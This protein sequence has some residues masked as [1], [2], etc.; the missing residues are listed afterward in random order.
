MLHIK[1]KDI[2]DKFFNNA[3][4]VLLCFG[5]VVIIIIEPK[6]LQF[7]VLKD[8]LTQSSVKLIVALGLMFPLLTAGTDL[9][10]GRQLGLS[11]VV[12]ASMMQVATY[13]NP[14]FPNLPAL[15]V[16]L[17]IL[18]ALAA[19]AVCGLIN[20]YMVAWLHLPPFI[21]TLGMSTIVYGANCIYYN[22][23]PNNAQPIG[24]I[25]PELT[26]LSRYQVF[27][28]M[29]LLIFIAAFVACFVWFLLNKTTY[30]K[31]IYAAGGNP[32]AAQISGVKVKPILLSAYIIES[33]LIGLAGVLEVARNSGANSSF[34]F[35]Y[36]F[37]AISAC[38][39]GG[40]SLSGG[41]GK[42]SGVIVGVIIFNVINYG[43]TF[44]GV[45][46]NWQQV[47]KGLIICM[48]VAL[49]MRKNAVRT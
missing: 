7:R 25:R 3:L 41:V 46:P 29:S 18:M 30:G 10:G 45:D 22:M 28:Q 39:V 26:I 13:P 19:V 37:D 36:E 43:L 34:G 24:G 14:F 17:P 47:F 48:A 20:G 8:I 21:A 35:S 38:V 16:I 9:S 11:A 4:I 1:V 44:I 6:F 12:V 49:D 31:S 2:K 32:V 15:P 33:L 27:G 23:E 42:V 5:V 40:V